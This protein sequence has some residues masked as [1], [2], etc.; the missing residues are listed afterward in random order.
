MK[1]IMRVALS[2]AIA[3]CFGYSAAIAAPPRVVVSIKPIHSLAA[4]L[5]QG[6][7]EPLLLVDGA[8]SPHSFAMRPSASRALQQADVVVWIG[9]EL[10]GFLA[11]SLSVLPERVRVVSLLHDAPE[12]ERLHLDDDGHDKVH[13]HHHGAEEH[14]FDP[15]IWLSLANA[16]AIAAH[17]TVVF[18]TFG[19]TDRL[20]A[21]AVALDR[22]LAELD[23]TIAQQLAA[24]RVHPFVVLHPA[25]NYWVKAYD[26]Q[27]AGVISANPEQGA[28]AGQM[29]NLRDRIAQQKAVC[30]F[31]EPQFGN[32]KVQAL[33]QQLNLRA[34]ILDPLGAD[35]PAGPMAYSAIVSAMATALA[36]C[37]NP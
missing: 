18:R 21:N 26:L 6:I 8:Q 35:I 25:Y 24:V 31:A 36:E 16:R 11:K 34:G 32:R 29:A 22:Q 27:Q 30:I 13:D 15:H 20:E 10:E 23:R 33:A 5:L 9:P 4:S 17:L 2:L 7:A 12:L 37:L 14:S 19:S 28:S 3:W 1:L